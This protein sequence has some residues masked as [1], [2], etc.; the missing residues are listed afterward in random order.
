[1]NDY[2][3]TTVTYTV[4]ELLARLDAKIDGLIEMLA[5]KAEQAELNSLSS[6]VAHLE[7]EQAEIL[8]IAVYKRWLIGLSVSVLGVGVA[9]IAFLLR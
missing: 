4:K 6:R 8:A 9:L 2:E 5:T 3:H 7:T 1:M